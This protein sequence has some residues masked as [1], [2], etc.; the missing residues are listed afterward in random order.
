MVSVRLRAKLSSALAEAA[1]ARARA[2]A[3]GTDRAVLAVSRTI[4]FLRTSRQRRRWPPSGWFGAARRRIGPDRSDARVRAVRSGLT[5]EVH[6][7]FLAPSRALRSRR[8]A[9][10]TR[11][12]ACPILPMCPTIGGHLYPSRD[13]IRG[14][15]V[16]EDATATAG[17]R[18]RRPLR[19][20]G[21]GRR[22]S[23]WHYLVAIALPPCLGVAALAGLVAAERIAAARDA[24]DIERSMATIQ[25]LDDLRQAVDAEATTKAAVDTLI[26]LGFTPRQ[27]G[28]SRRS[29][30]PGRRR[31]RGRRPTPPPAWCAPT[32]R[33]RHRSPPCAGSWPRPVSPRPTSAGRG[34]FR[35]RARAWET[36]VEYRRLLDL[37]ADDQRD[38]AIAVAA[39]QTRRGQPRDDERRRPAR[40]RV[41][42]RPAV[43]TPARGALPRLPRA[44]R[45]AA[46]GRASSSATSTRSTGVRSPAPAPAVAGAPASEWQKLETAE[47]VAPSTRYV[48]RQHRGASRPARPR[49]RAGGPEC[50][51]QG[52]VRVERGRELVPGHRGPAR[53]PRPPPPTGRRRRAAPSSPWASPPSL[54][55][56]TLGVLIALGGLIRRRL[57]AV[58]DG[59]QR[60]S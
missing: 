54:I 49:R 19:A 17:H 15:R 40:R 43:V 14:A 33:W 57:G 3:A 28:R 10:G 34:A 12:I 42:R 7:H 21:L 58:A 4:R 60:L 1:P 6:R 18:P 9:P 13:P 26:G 51:L 35:A 8:S 32:P 48:D 31:R 52:G 25:R 2:R 37:I 59:A 39:G 23:V 46:A 27:A 30:R 29:S 41:G 50:D 47:L 22:L 38:V 5:T 11:P 44:G 56:I 45:R 55:A 24:R 36:I 20:T 53:G 16:V